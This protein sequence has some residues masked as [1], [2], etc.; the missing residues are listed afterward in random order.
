MDDLLSLACV[1]RT[2]VEVTKRRVSFLSIRKWDESKSIWSI[3]DL[4]ARFPFAHHLTFSEECKIEGKGRD[5]CQ[6]VMQN[7]SSVTFKGKVTVNK[8]EFRVKEKTMLR[9]P[10]SIVFTCQRRSTLLMVGGKASLKLNLK[11]FKKV[12]WKQYY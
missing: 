7:F 5:F 6:E 10:N 3:K 12:P 8:V 1:A 9:K 2:F 4:A 11:V